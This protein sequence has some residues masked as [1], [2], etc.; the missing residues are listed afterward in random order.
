MWETLVQRIG[1]RRKILRLYPMRP[2]KTRHCLVSTRW[3]MPAAAWPSARRPARL[4]GRTYHAWRDGRRSLPCLM[5]PTAACRL[6][7]QCLAATLFRASFSRVWPLPVSPWAPAVRPRRQHEFL[8]RQPCPR[9]RPQGNRLRR[10]HRPRRPLLLRQQH[11]L[12]RPPPRCHRYRH[13]GSNLF[14]VTNRPRF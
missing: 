14:A 9:R 6:G 3:R 10:C 11:R 5:R 7:G 1:Q 4:P 2:Q 13:R 8:L 12:P